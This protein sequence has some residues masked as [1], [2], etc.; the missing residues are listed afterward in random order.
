MHIEQCHRGS[1]PLFEGHDLSIELY[2]A[3]RE[4]KLKKT[5][6]ALQQES[7][8]VECGRAKI[9]QRPGLHFTSFGQEN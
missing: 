8:S 5:T 4:Q 3:E 2:R 9:N 6:S 1:I 7:S